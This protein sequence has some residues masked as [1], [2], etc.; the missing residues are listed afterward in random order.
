MSGDQLE[1]GAEVRIRN[2][3]GT[4]VIKS[5]NKDGS[6]CLYGGTFSHQMFRDATPDK[7]RR[8]KNKGKRK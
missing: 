7:V 1:I 2:Q 4:Y 8:V 5:I 6:Y 3:P